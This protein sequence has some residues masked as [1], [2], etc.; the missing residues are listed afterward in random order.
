MPTMCLPFHGVST[1]DLKKRMF[2]LY[3]KVCV[4]VCLSFLLLSSGTAFAGSVSS[5]VPLTSWVY[6]ALDK[7][8]G[9]GLVDSS[10]QGARPYTRYEVARQ[11]D[12]TA[13]SS[14]VQNVSPAIAGLIRRLEKEVADTLSDLR[15]GVAN[16]YVKPREVQLNYIYQNGPESE[17]S[18]SGVIASQHALNYNNYG[19]DYGQNNA[20]ILVQGEARLGDYLLAEARPIVQV[21]RGGDSGSDLRLLDGRVA[22][23]LG[24]VEVSAGRQSLWWGQG[25]HGTLVLSNNTKPLDMFRITNP[26]PA[27]LP[28]IFKYLGPFRFDMFWSQ[29][30]EDRVVSEAYFAGMRVNFK[31]LPWVELGASRGVIFGGTKDYGQGEKIDI[32]ASDFITIISGKNLAGGDDTS[33]SVAAIDGRVRLP[34]LW[35]AEVYGEY[36]GE[37]ESNHFLAAHGWLAGVYLPQIE[38]S[39]RLSFTF[40]HTD[41]SRQDNMAPD[42]Y[43]HG[44]FKSG[45]TYQGKLLGHHVGGAA[46]DTYMEI[47]AI[48]SEKLLM[49]I[50][51]DYEERGFRQS[52]H[53][54]YTEG[55]LSADWS[56]SA[57]YSLTCSLAFG[58][59]ENYDFIAGNDE[60]LSLVSFGLR[61]HW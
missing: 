41:L 47:N 14:Q 50:A 5:Q 48:L 24:A 42:W 4:Y 45:Y 34:F 39:G 43:N 26:T 20:Q 28:W 54:K 19:F 21:Q 18:G 51:I 60:D 61:G 29:L 35:N 7:L 22:L 52:I 33:N 31:P 37:D 27:L 38:P 2:L 56:F 53:E 59:I 49:S 9:L 10:L 44:I 1:G 6:S 32:D 15:S 55:T 46:K 16:G 8:S 36:G 58:K 40:E 12:A 23:Q 13:R 57:H 11:V 25:R 3:K 17:V 30:E